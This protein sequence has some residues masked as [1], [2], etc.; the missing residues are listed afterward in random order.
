MLT[1]YK[2]SFIKQTAGKTKVCVNFY[3]GSMQDVEVKQTDGRGKIQTKTVR[4]YVRSGKVGQKMFSLSGR[5]S[6]S[7]VNNIL[8][9]ELAKDE[10][11][12]PIDEQKV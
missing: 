9:Q 3:E 5:L 12:L 11:R 6:L 8:N 1:D 7:E 2:I 10:T 4:Q